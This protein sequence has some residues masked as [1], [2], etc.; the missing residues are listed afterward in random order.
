MKYRIRCAKKKNGEKSVLPIFSLTTEHTQKE[1]PIDFVRL[2]EEER[3]PTLFHP[4][5]RIGQ[6]LRMGIGRFFS[7]IQRMGNRLFARI[8]A[9]RSR[10]TE[11]LRRKRERKRAKAPS[12]SLY[13]L[14]GACSATAL[15]AFLCVLGI[16][17]SLFRVYGGFYR[18][19][20]I[21]HLL[22]TYFDER[23]VTTQNADF[24]FSVDYVYNPDVPEGYVIDQ[25]P[26]PGVTRRVFG[27]NGHCELTLTVCRLPQAYLLPDL[28]GMSQRDAVL[29][30]RNHG[31]PFVLQTVYSDTAPLHTVVALD[32]LPGTAVTEQSTVILS[33]SQGR[34]ILT[35]SVPDLV[36]RTEEEATRLLKSLGLSVGSVRYTPSAYAAGTVLSQSTVPNTLLPSGDAVNLTVSSGVTHTE[37]TVPA[38]YGMT[39]AQAEIA[40][41]AEGLVVGKIFYVGKETPAASIITQSPLPGTP[42]TSAI[43]SVDLYLHGRS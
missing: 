8:G 22:G 43:V 17:F 18:T 25:V 40:L 32:P 14:L 20:E 23:T 35:V 42:I 5:M 6:R 13:L 30:L 27:T 26:T 33:V 31:I 2:F 24:V 4:R 19:V 41:R 16:L 36:G 9:Y 12:E 10:Y 38:L 21:P 1:D 15:V 39:I 34:P 28:V 3:L 7:R 11:R 37:R 29:E